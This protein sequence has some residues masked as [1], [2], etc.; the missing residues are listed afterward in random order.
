M[1]VRAGGYQGSASVHTHGL[2]VFA[3]TLHLVS[4]GACEVALTPDVTADGSKAADLLTRVESGA[5]DVCYFASSYLAGRVPQL[6]ALDLPF[7]VADRQS[8]Y[9]DL[10]GAQGQRMREAVAGRTGFDV[11]AFWDNGFRHLSN[12][13]QPIRHPSDC[14]GMSIRTLDNALHH[15]VFAGF[16][17][18]PETIDVRDLQEA[19]RSHRVDAQENPLTN[20]VNFGLHEIHRFHSLTG[21]FFGVALMLANRNW[22]EQL[23]STEKDWI[24]T[25]AAHAT[26]SQRA[27]ASDE[28]RRCLSVLRAKGAQILTA[29]E[30]DI[31]AF[32]AACGVQP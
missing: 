9:S 1:I 17:F 26:A 31:T 19:V 13:L 21:H 4:G 30:C 2:Q 24:A 16:G 32:R 22:L 11:L 20:T 23:D 10:D 3:Q 6:S 12:R 28:D 5:L 8:A 29:D 18:H 14:A 27:R 25:A 7:A 15:A